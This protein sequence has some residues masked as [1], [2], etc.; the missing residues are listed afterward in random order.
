MSIAG[1]L[2]VWVLGSWV[3]VAAM[4]SAG[5]VVYCLCDRFGTL[6]YWLYR[7]ADRG[8]RLSQ[9]RRLARWYVR[10]THVLHSIKRPTGFRRMPRGRPPGRE[11]IT[12]A[13]RSGMLVRLVLL[14]CDSAMSLAGRTIR[15]LCSWFGLY[16]IIGATWA[17]H[18][19]S[20]QEAGNDVL[21]LART[22][23]VPVGVLALAFAVATFLLVNAV[24]WRRRGLSK[25]RADHTV[26]GFERLNTIRVSLARM[27]DEIG[28]AL[29]EW[30]AVMARS[31]SCAT[32]WGGTQL[33]TLSAHRRGLWRDEF[34]VV[35]ESWAAD[36][37][38][39]EKITS[40]DHQIAGVMAATPLAARPVISD[41]RLFL[42]IDA[43][44]PGTRRVID[45][46][47][48]TAAD[49]RRQYRH[50]LDMALE[51]ALDEV[52]EDIIGEL[53]QRLAVV[54]ERLLTEPCP[55]ASER[56][57][58]VADAAADDAARCF[59]PVLERHLRCVEVAK[60]V[61]FEEKRAVT[62]RYQDA[63]DQLVCSLAGSLKVVLRENL[64]ARSLHTVQLQHESSAQF[65][66]SLGQ[67]PRL[68]AGRHLVITD[69]IVAAVRSVRAHSSAV[70]HLQ[71]EPVLDGCL[72]E[73][74]YKNFID[75][76]VRNCCEAEA[77]LVSCLA[78]LDRFLI[79]RS[80]WAQIRAALSR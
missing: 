2:Y 75:E 3:V 79:P 1:W 71:L 14:L 52:G 17:T 72:D 18:R 44:S 65:W 16:S 5:F 57:A 29:V 35:H 36:L 49:R 50:T 32:S 55:S 80:R 54:S 11:R 6:S 46:L 21:G 70:T 73:H 43:F 24:S 48:N 27:R 22:L 8:A 64:N 60:L 19:H 15:L 41:P 7:T 74:R 4:L 31:W 20:L 68:G 47:L 34:D 23:D 59:L 78:S 51:V 26:D 10:V 39:L 37:V 53:Q 67:S 61:D 12:S 9:R 28:P 45:D 69:V 77:E 42:G 40:D 63:V 30:H 66:A 13:R 58:E 76:R 33:A 38:E 56:Y 62:E 25:W